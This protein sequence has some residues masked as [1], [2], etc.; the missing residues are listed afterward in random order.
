MD[1]HQKVAHLVENTTSVVKA[2][3][4][5]EVW[6][7]FWDGT[8]AVLDKGLYNR[9]SDFRMGGLG[10]MMAVSEGEGT[11]LHYDKKDSGR[12]LPNFVIE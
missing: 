5:P 3:A 12:Y 4:R 2:G 8:Q 6:K 1:V 7:T 11:K 10:N 9:T